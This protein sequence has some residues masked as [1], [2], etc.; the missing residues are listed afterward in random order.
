MALKNLNKISLTEVAKI[1]SGGECSAEEVLVACLS[2]IEEREETVKAWAH[3]DKELILTYAQTLDNGPVIGPLHGVPIGVK[4]VLNTADMPTQMGSPIYR[5]YKAKT[6]AACVAIL[7]A[8]GAIILGKTVTCEF[9]GSFPGAT[10]NPHNSNYTPGGS[11]SGS[12]AAVADFMVPAAFGTQTG[13]SVL[14][15][16]AFCGTVGYK[17]SYNMINRAGLMFAAENLD[18]IGLLTRTVDDADLLMSVLLKRPLSKTLP[19][20]AIATIGLCRTHL[21]EMASDETIFAVNDSVERLKAKNARFIEITLP[22]SFQH[23]NDARNIINDFERSR[24]MADHWYNDRELLSENIQGQLE[25]GLS[26]SYKTYKKALNL[27]QKSRHEIKGIFDQVDFVLAPSTHGEAPFGLDSTG[28]PKFQGLWTILHV[29][30]IT[31][32]THS[33]P[34]NLPVGIQLIGYNHRDEHLLSWARWVL[35]N[36]GSWQ[37]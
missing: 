18:T 19:R 12:G 2:R 20:K 11:S 37:N 6:D 32:P 27:A 30:T 33:G 5:G 31:L 22:P 29:P 17:P 25:R 15:P 35:E 4:D 9:A 21:W 36:L 23:L 34:N 10:T 28:D 8:A 1:I 7:R 24:V 13:G 26:M 3:I 14:R 16:A